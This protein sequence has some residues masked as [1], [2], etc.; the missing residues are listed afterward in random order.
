MR[1]IV[2]MG[3]IVLLPVT[4]GCCYVAAG[5][6]AASTT[7]TTTIS[8]RLQRQAD[9]PTQ[10]HTYCDHAAAG[11]ASTVSTRHFLKIYLVSGHLLFLAISL[12]SPSP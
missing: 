10:A 4:A 11:A 1:F 5:G 3:T 9:L 8:L 7:T 12:R 6:G 2:A